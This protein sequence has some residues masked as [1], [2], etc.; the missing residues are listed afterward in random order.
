VL[1]LLELVIS[2][3]MNQDLCKPYTDEEIS[4]ALFQIGPLKALGPDGFPTCFF[5]KNWELMKADVIQAMKQFFQSGTMPACVNE[6]AIVLLP[7]KDEPEVLRDFRPI[8]LCN[9][10]YKV[11]YKCLVNR[12]RPMLQDIIAWTQS[13]FILGRLIMDNALIA[14]ECLHETQ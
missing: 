12:L 8:S 9:I 7:K 1:S 6:T 5:Q 14:F 11:V 4:H 3:N 2:D 10:I 13:A